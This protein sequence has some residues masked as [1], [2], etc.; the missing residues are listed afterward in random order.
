METVESILAA[1]PR[2]TMLS[3][4][5]LQW[6]DDLSLEIIAELARGRATGR[7]C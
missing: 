2:P 5:D 6:A 3:F 1:L 7:C 4:E